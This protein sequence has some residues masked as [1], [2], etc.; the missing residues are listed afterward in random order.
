MKRARPRAQGTMC[1]G[2]RATPSR[3]A[4]HVSGTPPCR[5]GR[6]PS[7][8]ARPP[9]RMTHA[10]ARAP[11]VAVAAAAAPARRFAPPAL[12]RGMSHASAGDHPQGMPSHPGPGFSSA[13][14]E[15]PADFSSQTFLDPG[16]NSLVP[17]IVS[18]AV[19]SHGQVVSFRCRVVSV[20]GQS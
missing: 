5:A 2:W 18:Q 19:G 8:S 15:I 17:A 20:P 7:A 9:E 11:P 12:R 14:G 1:T 4:L 6:P 13:P 16:S 10:R 3:P